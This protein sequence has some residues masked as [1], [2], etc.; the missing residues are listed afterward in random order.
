MIEKLVKE[1]IPITDEIVDK[2]DWSKLKKRYINRYANFKHGSFNISSSAFL[3]IIV[4]AYNGDDKATSVIRHI[5]ECVNKIS[6]Y[7][8]CHTRFK[9]AFY[10]MIKNMI[11]SLDEKPDSKNSDFKNWI[12]ELT[13]FANLCENCHIEILDIE[14]P[15]GNGKSADFSVRLGDELCF[16]DFD[17]IT[18]QNID[19]YK[20]ETSDTI[21]AFLNTKISEK[22]SAKMKDLPDGS[23]TEF[24]ILPVVEFREGM[25]IFCYKVDVSK[26]LPIMAY[27]SNIIDG[28]T[29]YCLMDLNEICVEL[30]TRKNILV[31]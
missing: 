27:F 3:D 7:I 2:K 14:K 9:S 12:S 26:S 10:N 28:Q 6:K 16:L 20:H 22:Y 8:T 24:R 5:N 29:E 21:N 19:P 23:Y 18:Y 25:E 13:I 4:F 17:I 11:M 30:R 15:L 1:V 31:V